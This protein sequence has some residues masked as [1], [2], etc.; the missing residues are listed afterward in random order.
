MKNKLNIGLIGFGVVG[1]GIYTLLQQSPALNANIK[2]IAIRH[3]EKYRNAPAQLFTTDYTELLHDPEINVIVELIDDAERAYSIVMQAIQNGKHVISANKKMIASHLPELIAL[4]RKHKVSLLYEAAVAAGIPIIRNL[5]EYYSHDQLHSLSGIING[6]TNYILTQGSEHGLAY[7]E[8]LDLA[9]QLG[10]AESDPSL[11]VEGTDAANKL[12]ILLKHAFGIDCLPAQIPHYG[13]TKIGPHETRFAEE[14]GLVIKLVANALRNEADEVVAFV[15]PQ[16]INR[17]EWLARVNNEQNGIIVRSS[18]DDEQYF[19]G[20]GAGRFPTASAV[21]SDLFALKD[22][23]RYGYKKSSMHAATALCNEFTLKLL[24]RFDTTIK[25]LVEDFDRILHQVH[26][27]FEQQLIG[28]IK[29]SALRS[30]SW[31]T[32]PDVSFVH[33][34]N[35]YNYQPRKKDR[36]PS[37]KHEVEIPVTD[38]LNQ[39]LMNYSG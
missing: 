31:A 17:K 24:V 19:Q 13:I 11:D 30:A 28:E 5:E 8:S 12:C 10:F 1:E 15:M 25:H 20:K 6:S 33:L 9:Q 32:H 34:D 2:R 21:L 39:G 23:Y 36:K 27:P 4:Q 3:A 29:L 26:G 14:N 16:F 38:V 22:S 35:G 37:F 18:F 7:S